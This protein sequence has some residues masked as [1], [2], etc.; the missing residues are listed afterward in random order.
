MAAAQI[1]QGA[2]AGLASLAGMATAGI[3][4]KYNKKL[5]DYQ[6]DINIENWN[7]QN[8]YNSPINQRK[9]LEEAG[10]NPAAVFGSNSTSAGNAG[11]IAQ[12]QRQGVD[13]SQSML[14]AGQLSQLAATIQKTKADAR[15]NNAQAENM[16]IQNLY[17]SAKEQSVID[18]YI[19]NTNL[20]K[21]KESNLRTE[22]DRTLQ[23]ISNMKVQ[24]DKMNK[25]IDKMGEEIALLKAQA[26]T[27]E[28]RAVLLR[29]QQTTELFQQSLL[30]AQESNQRSQAS[31]NF[32][33][34][35]YYG[36]QTQ[37]INADLLVKEF[38]QKY[39]D[40]Y[41]ADPDA[42][43][44]NYISQLIQGGLDNAVDNSIL[45]TAFKVPKLV[46]DWKK[47][48]QRDKYGSNVVYVGH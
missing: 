38:K 21:Q 17:Q 11:Q 12:Y 20:N 35:G 41:G 4:H 34:E 24:S 19:S 15:L 2:T 13:I 39:R 6:N 44:I 45:G 30:S 37:S 28:E 18:N 22:N 36:A 3:Q 5:A 10:I 33:M 25:E 40:R 8:E 42:A 14:A 27:E 32:V 43:T 23:E 31:L 46:K 1:I 48:K 47:K 29:L 7:M 9:R 16:E 26:S